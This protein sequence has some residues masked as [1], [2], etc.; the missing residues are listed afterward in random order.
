[1]LWMTESY[2]PMHYVENG[3]LKGIA[4]DIL[5]RVFE[6]KEVVFDPQRLRVYPWA[7][8]YKTLLTDEKS[9]IFT[10]ASTPERE[11]LFYLVGPV[12]TTNV[13]LLAKPER[14]IRLLHVNDLR[15]YT[16]GVVRKDVGETLLNN[17]E[18]PSLRLMQVTESHDI[19][20]ML[21]RDR[22]DM[23]SYSEDIAQFYMN[24]L[25]EDITR[26]DVVKVLQEMKQYFAFHR[27]APRW[28]IQ[29]F[30]DEIDA[31]R[32]NGELELI[33]MQYLPTM[34]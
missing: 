10:M 5:M 22:V 32:E 25:S 24:S 16:I 33:R 15:K 28:F 26:L 18:L 21:L 23:I 9:A 11:M 1:M 6:R 7:R 14:Q 19:I 2:P 17:Y 13:S 31:M 8:A 29:A 20:K 34:N 3:Q 27:H 12:G 30:Q 4:V